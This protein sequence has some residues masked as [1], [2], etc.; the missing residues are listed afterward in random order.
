MKD[1]DNQIKVQA[2]CTPPARSADRGDTAVPSAPLPS[3]GRRYYIQRGSPA[4]ERTT[5]SIVCGLSSESRRALDDLPQADLF[6]PPIL[7]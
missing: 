6:S 5:L 7:A 4:Q 3:T 2:D 1:V